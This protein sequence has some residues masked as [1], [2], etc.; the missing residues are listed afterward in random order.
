MLAFFSCTMVLG[1]NEEGVTRDWKPFVTFGVRIEGGG[2]GQCLF[3][4]EP[5]KVDR[6]SLE[7]DSIVESKP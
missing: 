4:G 3:P 6:V 2:F 1:M 5:I 7:T